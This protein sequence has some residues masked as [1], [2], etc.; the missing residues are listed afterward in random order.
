[1]SAQAQSSSYEAEVRTDE[2][3]QIQMLML[4][5]SCVPSGG[6]LHELIQKSLEVSSP[7]VLASPQQCRDFS[8]TG[9]KKYLEALWS[10]SSVNLTQD[11]QD[12]VNLQNDDATM[13]DAVKELSIAQTQ[14]G[15]K[16]A[17]RPLSG[18]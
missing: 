15:F 6:K 16:F 17:I 8:F 11:E 1:M 9:I 10:S 14:L 5:L 4:T 18:S 2:I 13:R 3:R 12:I 7:G